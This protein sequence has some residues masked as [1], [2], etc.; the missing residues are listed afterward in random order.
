[1]KT[2][3]YVAASI[4]SAIMSVSTIGVQIVMPQTETGPNTPPPQPQSQAANDNDAAKQAPPP[5][6]MGR[7]VD[8]TV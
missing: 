6:G 4:E 8:K 7:H 3:R 2:G 5:P 1:L